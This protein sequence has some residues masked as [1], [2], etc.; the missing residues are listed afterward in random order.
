[1]GKPGGGCNIIRGHDNVQGSTDMG[2]LSDTLPMYYGLSDASWKYYCKGWGVDY[3]EFIKRFAVSTKEPKQGGA[4]VKNTVFEEYFY[5]DPQNPEDRNW[6]NEK[7]WSLSK[8]WQGVLKEE[9]LLLAV[10]FAFFG[11]KEPVSPLWLTLQKFSKPS[12]N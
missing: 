3:D 4:P 1:M 8:W 6:R 11:F 5:H 2:N 10:N 9:R 12:T 7:G